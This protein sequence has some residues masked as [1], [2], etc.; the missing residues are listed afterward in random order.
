[1]YYEHFGGDC[2]DPIVERMESLIKG[3]EHANILAPFST[4][5]LFL[6]FLA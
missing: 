4:L 6:I 1:M 2:M 5:L 3:S